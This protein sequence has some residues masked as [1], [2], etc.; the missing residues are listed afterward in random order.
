MWNKYGI[1]AGAMLIVTKKHIDT[2]VRKDFVIII[3]G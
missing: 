2:Y 3:C 1:T